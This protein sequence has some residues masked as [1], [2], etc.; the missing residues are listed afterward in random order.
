MRKET[1]HMSEEGQEHLSQHSLWSAA[2][3]AERWHQD[4]ERRRVDFAEAT[5][6]MFEAAGLEPGHHVLDIA[7]GTGDQS[8]LAARRVGPGGSVLATDIS[9]EMLDLPARVANLE[10]LTP[11]PTP[12]TDPAHL[13]PHTHPIHSIIP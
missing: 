4:I 10:G 11:P 2:E 7:A 8:I 3:V 6:C 1:K 12:L 13:N 9:A 5:Q